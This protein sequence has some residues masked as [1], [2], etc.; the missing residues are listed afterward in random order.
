MI[1]PRWRRPGLAS[2]ALALFLWAAMITA[3]IG[4]GRVLSLW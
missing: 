4:A 3:V 2:V 1:G